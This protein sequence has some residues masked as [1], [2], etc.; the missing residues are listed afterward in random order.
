MS[1]SNTGNSANWLSS[2]PPITAYPFTISLWF[3][4][5]NITTNQ[6][7]LH[8]YD[9]ATALQYFSLKIQSSSVLS[10]EARAG[11][12]TASANTSNTVVQNAW[13]H[14]LARGISAT[15]R[16]VSLNGGTA[17]TSTLNRTPTGIDTAHY[18]RHDSAEAIIGRLAEFGLWDVDIGAG[19]V[20]DLYT[21]LYCPALV[22]KPDLVAYL[23][24]LGNDS[25]EPDSIGA[26]DATINGTMP[27]AA[28]IS[29]FYYATYAI[30]ATDATMAET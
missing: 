16:W 7:L 18:G 2:T 5:T 22:N 26:F 4:P 28:H 6:R 25:P 10:F 20:T 1:R 8:L 14:V 9:A 29:P 15:S 12:T 21:N 19:A 3:Y 17:G 24:F 13:N 30:A 27:Q 23:K 11:G